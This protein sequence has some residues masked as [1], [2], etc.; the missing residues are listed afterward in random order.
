MQV[1]EAKTSAA[2]N[3]TIQKKRQPFF[4]KEGQ[5]SFFSNSTKHVN[6]FFTPAT[7]QPKLTIGQPNDKYEVEAD[8]MADKVVQRLAAPDVQ[9]RNEVAVQAKP[10]AASVTPLVQKKCAECEQEAKNSRNEEEDLVQESPIELQ[11]KSIFDS[12][13]EPPDDEGNIQRKCAGC[14]KEEKKLQAKAENSEPSLRTPSL[15]SSLTSSKGGGSPL[16]ES[17]RTQMENSFGTDFSRVR[18]H[19]NSSAV[20]MNKDLNAQAFSH[21][22]DIYFNQGK[23]DTNSTG[24]KKLL[25]HE[26]THTVQQGKNIVRR[27]EFGNNI[28]LDSVQGKNTADLM[29]PYSDEAISSELYGISSIPIQHSETA[30]MSIEINYPLLRNKWKPFF[31][32]FTNPVGFD[33]LNALSDQADAVIYSD[34]DLSAALQT[35]REIENAGVNTS[36]TGYQSAYVIAQNEYLVRHPEQSIGEINRP[37]GAPEDQAVSFLYWIW[38]EHYKHKIYRKASFKK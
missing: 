11:R 22:S 19:T 21:G 15:E 12:N 18:V 24:G 23:Y 36:N 16:P 4:N 34:E 38:G 3:K 25:A 13:A 1:A 14:E 5:D 31:I 26:L 17:T 6:S 8:A 29:G 7:V 9:A 33:V 32:R 37:A 20:Q 35:F 30:M 28:T 10:L 2:A 27:K